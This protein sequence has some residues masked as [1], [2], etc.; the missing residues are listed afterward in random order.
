MP[1]QNLHLTIDLD[2]QQKA[3]QILQD[4]IETRRAKPDPFTGERVEVEQGSIVALNPS[5][6]EVLAM[7]NIP[8]F[9]NNRFSTEV[10]VDYYL[11]L[12]RNDYTR[13]N[14]V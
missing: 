9:D 6:G 8:T 11:G 1:G 10:P 3:Y 13:N 4:I 7:V 5:T 14:F 12:A 2:L